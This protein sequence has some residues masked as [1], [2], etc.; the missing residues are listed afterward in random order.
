M[1]SE[2]EEHT[3]FVGCTCDHEPEDHDWTSCNVDG[4]ACTGAW[5]E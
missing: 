4:C 1:A 5:E 2:Y 3:A